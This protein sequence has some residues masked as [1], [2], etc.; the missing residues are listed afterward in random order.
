MNLRIFL[1]CFFALAGIFF[2]CSESFAGPSGYQRCEPNSNCVLGEFLF[3]E[4]YNPVTTDSCVIDIRNPS[5]DI[6]IDSAATN[7]NDDGW[8]AYTYNTS[9]PE[10]FY[11]A[12]MCCTVGPDTACMDK[13]FILGTSFETVASIETNTDFIRES[14]F[15]FSGKADSGSTTTLTDLDLIQP[16]DYWNE[17]V[18]SFITGSNAGQE[19]TVSGFSSASNTLTFSPALPQ[20]VAA[21]DKYILKREEKL[22][23]HIWNFTN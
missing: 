10:G 18:I 7:Y 15:D 22:I 12:V 2:Y 11:R 1:L 16:D 3:D 8:H 21:G 20:V 6:V 19:R 5:G 13:S 14:T 9:G 23:S 17:Y 4:D